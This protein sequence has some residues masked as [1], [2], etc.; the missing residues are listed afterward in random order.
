MTRTTALVFAVLVMVLCG[1]PDQSESSFDRER[2][3]FSLSCARNRTPGA[4]CLTSHPF[5]IPLADRLG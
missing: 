1:C 4:V 3:G 5:I 2:S